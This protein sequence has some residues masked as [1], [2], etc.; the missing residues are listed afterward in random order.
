[1]LGDEGT[2]VLI[3]YNL[4]VFSGDAPVI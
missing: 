2:M 3:S 1:L 4:S